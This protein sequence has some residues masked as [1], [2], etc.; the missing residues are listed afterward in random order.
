MRDLHFYYQKRPISSTTYAEWAAVLSRLMGRVGSDKQFFGAMRRIVTAR[1]EWLRMLQVHGYRQLQ[2]LRYGFARNCLPCSVVLKQRSLRQCRLLCCP[3]CHARTVASIA[4]HFRLAIH[5]LETRHLDYTFVRHKEV[6]DRGRDNNLFDRLI[7]DD[8]VKHMDAEAFMNDVVAYHKGFNAQ[9][10]KRYFK[11]AYLA[12]SWYSYVPLIEPGEYVHDVGRFIVV[13]STVALVPAGWNH[14]DKAL[15]VC[16]DTSQHLRAL[17][18]GNAFRYPAA[19]MRTD[20][21]IMAGM[22]NALHGTHFFKSYG[23][24][25][26][27]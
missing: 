15:Q 24:L 5:E 18:V 8:N 27:L 26:S 2:G 3:F 16:D 6:L 10:R 22:L 4:A 7:M 12:H 9:I 13:Q 19:W 20:P 17:F 1:R 11:S 21:L 14:A 23:T 25:R